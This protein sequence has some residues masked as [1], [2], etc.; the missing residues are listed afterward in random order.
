VT[1]SASLRDFLAS[2]GNKIGRP[3]MKTGAGK[4]LD[5]SAHRLGH[6]RKNARTCICVHDWHDFSTIICSRLAT[7]KNGSGG[8]GREFCSLTIRCNGCSLGGRPAQPA[9][10]AAA[11]MDGKK[12]LFVSKVN[13][14]PRM[15]SRRELSPQEGPCGGLFCERRQNDVSLCGARVF[16]TVDRSCDHCFCQALRSLPQR[17]E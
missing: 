17:S 6:L 4:S 9:I 16:D 8:S 10:S 11:G 7:A 15:T 3:K 12:T 1:G 5:L 14:A 2:Q 13:A